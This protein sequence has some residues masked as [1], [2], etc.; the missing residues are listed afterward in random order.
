MSNITP[1]RNTNS[2]IY[3]PTLE[4]ALLL[5]AIFWG[6]SYGLTKQ[7]LIYTSVMM[8]IAIRFSLTC[9]VLLPM[10]VRDLKTAR[11]SDWKV[12]L[13]TGLILA[14]IFA[15]EVM[16]VFKT[17]ASN[18]AFLISLSVIFT[19]F[20]EA[21]INKSAINKTMLILVLASIVGV[22][23][24]TR[25]TRFEMELNYGDYFI[26]SAAV[27]RALMVT[28]TKKLTD[29]KK[30]TNGT[31]TCIQSFVVAMCALGIVLI[32]SDLN[33]ELPTHYLFWGMMCYLVVC[34]TLYAFF[35]QNH[36]VRKLSPTKV[37]LLMGSEPLFGALFA[38]VWL[39]ESLSIIQI[40]GGCII[41]VCVIMASL[42]KTTD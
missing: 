8:F 30:I 21:L 24:L 3:F 31:L 33:F 1:A 14:A 36:A 17:T 23:L 29:G 26:L 41:F 20:V 9:L 4:A 16:G 22:F 37:S 34:C 32:D 10:T 19:L 39:N 35:V 18:A 2:T 5:V 27:L 38:V 6:T 40:I 7:S 13:P 28:T 15:F 12:A 25:S 42:L 11:S